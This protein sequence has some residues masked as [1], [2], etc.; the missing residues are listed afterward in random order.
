MGGLILLDAEIA[1]RFPDWADGGARDYITGMFN[2]LRATLGRGTP[3]VPQAVETPYSIPNGD[4]GIPKYGET[5]IVNDLIKSSYDNA[6][7]T[8]AAT[9]GKSAT[10]TVLARNAVTSA[11]ELFNGIAMTLVED[12][13]MRLYAAAGYAIEQA[14][15]AVTQLLSLQSQPGGLQV[16]PSWFVGPIPP[17]AIRMQPS[18][19]DLNPPQ[20]PGTDQ[21]GVMP[22]MPYYPPAS[23]S[24]SEARNYYAEGERRIADQVSRMRAAGK[25]D[26]EIA[27]WAFEAR[28]EIRT[29]TRALMADRISAAELDITDPNRTWEGLIR[30]KMLRKGI[31]AEEAVLDIARSA[32]TSRDSVNKAHG[33]DPENPKIPSSPRVVART[34]LPE[35]AHTAGRAAGPLTAVVEGYSAYQDYRSGEST[36]AEAIGQGVGGTLGGIGGGMATGALVG[37]F[38]GPVGTVVG[39]IVGGIA[40][41][42]GGGSFG[43]TI[44]GWFD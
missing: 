4:L 7:K 3:A 12:D 13:Y 37:S 21:Q 30:D 38:A 42:I 18:A 23:L 1:P 31:T 5:K 35:I 15:N 40:G 28:N 41:G 39:G 10:L 20:P 17:G 8:M 27:R 43:K 6:T 26:P 32:S 34:V 33:V 44:G 9:V 16:Y 29:K 14:R 24:G 25:S 36:A 22:G 19:T 2:G 11:V